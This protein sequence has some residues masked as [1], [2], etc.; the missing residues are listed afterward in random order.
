MAKTHVIRALQI[1]AAILV[2]VLAIGLYRAKS[3]AART[4]ARVRELQEEISE[5][6]ATL[7]ELRAEIARRESPASIEALAEERLGA[8]VG[9]ESPALPEAAIGERLPP[10]QPQ[11]PHP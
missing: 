10:P 2:A 5:R 3:D 7:R 4:E 11:R 1:I 9:S 8:V 6:E